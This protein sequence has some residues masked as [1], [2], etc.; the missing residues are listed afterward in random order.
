M[1]YYEEM[2]RAAWPG[3]HFQQR[4]STRFAV[5][6][7]LR[8][9]CIGFKAPCILPCNRPGSI[10]GFMAMEQRHRSLS[11]INGPELSWQDPW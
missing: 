9:L 1:R 4:F 2:T 3:S 11:W 7:A 5:T 8:H 6:A 10:S